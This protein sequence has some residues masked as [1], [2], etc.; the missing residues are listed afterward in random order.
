VALIRLHEQ[1]N[2]LVAK[3]AVALGEFHHDPAFGEDVLPV[4]YVA[5]T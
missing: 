4:A 5:A 2:V 1:D 3:S